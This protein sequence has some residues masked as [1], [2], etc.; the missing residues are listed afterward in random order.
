MVAHFVKFL[1]VIIYDAGRNIQ[2]PFSSG[3]GGD[4]F[5][6]VKLGGARF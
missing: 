3:V 5:G 2:M 6:G 1:F 4:G